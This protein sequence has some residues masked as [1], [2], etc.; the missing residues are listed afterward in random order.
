MRLRYKPWA[1]PEMQENEF[2]YFDPVENKG[3]WREVFGNDNP[4]YLEIGAGRGK[5]A[6][7]SAE[8]NPDVNYIAL[9]MDANA[10][11]YASR[12]FKES[13]LENLLGVRTVAQRLLEFFD[14]SE[15]DR[16]Y[17]NFCNPWPKNRQHKKRLSHPRFLE[18]YKVVLKNGGTI[19]LKT[20]DRPFFD[21]TV[22]YFEDSVFE[23]LDVDYDL[24]ADKGDNIVTEYESKWRSR[25]IKINYIKVKLKK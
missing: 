6:L 22:E 9:E 3:R 24:A 25:G 16:I 12:K 11:V 5:F 13:Q 17:I 7:I 18:L 23:I 8:R 10:F 19:E 15:I 20:D 4:I 1:I 14:E 21:D 2:I